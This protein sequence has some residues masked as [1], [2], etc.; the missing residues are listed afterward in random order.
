M[1]YIGI[2]PGFTGAVAALDEQGNFVSVVD[3]PTFE[4]VGGAKKKTRLDVVG[5]ARII[6]DLK[7]CKA[8]L[9][10]VHSMPE[11]GITGAFAFGRGLGVWEGILA[12]LEVSTH[13]VSPLKWKK[14]TMEGMGKE[15]DASRLRALALFPTA[16]LR[17]KKHHGRADAL[18][19]ALYLYRQERS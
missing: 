14:A 2:D 17:L 3:V 13:M 7:P 8:V 19:M 9:E 12:A 10:D 4:I 1:L 5:I 18:L 6:R 16:D 11:Q 15:K